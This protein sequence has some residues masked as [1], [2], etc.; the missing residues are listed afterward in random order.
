[1]EDFTPSSIEVLCAL[2]ECCGRYLYKLPETSEKMQVMLDTLIKKK[3]AA[4]NLDTRILLMLENSYYSC[5]P[6]EYVAKVEKVRTPLELYVRKLLLVDLNKNTCEKI[7]KS[8][9]KLPWKDSKVG[10]FDTKDS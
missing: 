1:M 9:R 10:L 6:P 4:T 7:L 8:L 2:L 3:K 5:K